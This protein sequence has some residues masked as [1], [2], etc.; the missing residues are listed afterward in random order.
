MNQGTTDGLLGRISWWKMM[1]VLGFG[2]LVTRGGMCNFGCTAEATQPDEQLAGHL[3]AL[4]ERR[5]HGI[6]APDQGVERPCT[7]TPA[8]A[9]R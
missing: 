6:D 5:A 9:R 8:M 2:A 1:A 4:C 7:T 3:R